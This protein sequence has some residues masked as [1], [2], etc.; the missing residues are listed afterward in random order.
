MI[1]HYRHG[2]VTGDWLREIRRLESE[3]SYAEGSL[4]PEVEAPRMDDPAYLAPYADI[5]E[6]REEPY[7]S[8]ESIH[9][10][11]RVFI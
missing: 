11:G 8:L 4:A 7:E 10:V 2:S 3:P 1:S 9:G 5:D 6:G